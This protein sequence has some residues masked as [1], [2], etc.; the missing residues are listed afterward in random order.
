MSELIANHR[1]TPGQTTSKEVGMRAYVKWLAACWTSSVG[2]IIAL[3]WTGLHPDRHP[4]VF[5]WSVSWFIAAAVAGLTRNVFL[6]M[7]PQRFALARWER[8]SRAYERFGLA[9]FCWLLKH[10]PFGW[11]NPILRMRAFGRC[12]IQELLREMNFAEGAHW[13]GGLITIGLGIGC[14]IAGHQ[15]VGLSFAVVLVPTHV[16]PVMLQ[17]ANRARILRLCA[18]QSRMTGL[19]VIRP[20]LPSD[21]P[22]AGLAGSR[23]P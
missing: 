7:D 17:R 21:Q 12:A 16:Y 6:R 10:T 9:G 14:F 2:S 15:A 18:R 5:A 23:S 13:L 22:P 3:G 1:P 4:L 19:E 8:E 11:L 20:T